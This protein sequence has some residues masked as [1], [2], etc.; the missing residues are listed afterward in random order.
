MYLSSSDTICL[1]VIDSLLIANTSTPDMAICCCMASL[2]LFD[3]NIAVGIDTHL[4]SD[5]KRFSGDILRFHM[6]GM[7]LKRPSCRQGKIAA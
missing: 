6:S 1:G 7:T 3:N 4:R 5:L 2:Q